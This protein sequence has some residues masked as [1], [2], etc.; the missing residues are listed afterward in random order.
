MEVTSKHRQIVYF[1]NKILGLSY[2]YLHDKY[3]LSER[4]LRDI[5]DG[6]EFLSSRYISTL[7]LLD[8]LGVSIPD[9]LPPESRAY[10]LKTQIRPKVKRWHEINNVSLRSIS[11]ITHVNF[12]TIRHIY[13]EVTENVEVKTI[14][15]ILFAPKD[16]SAEKSTLTY[17]ASQYVKDMDRWIRD[18]IPTKT[19]CFYCDGLTPAL[20]GNRHM[21]SR[22][23]YDSFMSYMQ[24]KDELDKLAYAIEFNPDPS[25]ALEE[26]GIARRYRTCQVCGKKFVD[27]SKSDTKYCSNKCYKEAQKA[28]HRESRRKKATKYEKVCPMCGTKFVTTYAHKIYCS[29]ECS[30]KH[31]NEVRRIKNKQKR[32]EGDVSGR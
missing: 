7:K 20:I 3:Q 9:F 32:E 4:A 17:D 11:R 31:K 12:Q 15:L 16:M 5:A 25:K 10:I 2:K 14:R 24:G 30:S 22:V 28:I 29:K 27:N 8:I 13:Y 23:S 18:G 26:A 1:Y 21:Y 19:I 6:K